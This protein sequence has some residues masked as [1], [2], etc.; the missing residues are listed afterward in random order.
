[1]RI[2]LSA[3]ETAPDKK[4]AISA[5]MNGGGMKIF[6]SAVEQGAQKAA[7]E[8]MLQPPPVYALEP[9]VL[10]LPAF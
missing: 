9:Y 5:I 7:V 4:A 8:K 2:F 1:M 3:T 10:L 6:L